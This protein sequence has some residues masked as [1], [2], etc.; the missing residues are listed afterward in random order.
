MVAGA[1]VVAPHG[2]FALGL[3]LAEFGPGVFDRAMDAL[4]VKRDV[5]KGAGFIEPDAGGVEEIGVRW[6][7]RWVFA[8]DGDAAGVDLRGQGGLEARIVG[9]ALD[10]G[11][12]RDEGTHHFLN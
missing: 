8:F 11:R 4:F 5:G 7:R 9:V 1:L 12:R 6:R 2:G 10:R 3:E